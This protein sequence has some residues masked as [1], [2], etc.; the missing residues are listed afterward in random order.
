MAI[1]LL[2]KPEL[3]SRGSLTPNATASLLLLYAI[4]L[5]P[6]SF[7]L[8]PSQPCLSVGGTHKAR[9]QALVWGRFR[10][11]KKWLAV[12]RAAFR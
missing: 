8:T 2:A 9:T 7:G 6:L 11:P 4:C 1:A 10:E 5:A 12:M 3:S